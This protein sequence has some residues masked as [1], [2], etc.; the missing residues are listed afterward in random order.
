MSILS[1]PVYEVIKVNMNYDVINLM[2]EQLVEKCIG[3][4]LKHEK[5]EKC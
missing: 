1:M 4:N 2:L 3:N 5:T